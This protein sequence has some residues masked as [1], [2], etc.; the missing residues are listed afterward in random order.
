MESPGIEPGSKQATK[1]L[2]T[3][4]FPDWVFDVVFDQ[5]QSHNTYLLNFRNP[6]EAHENLGLNLRFPFIDRYK[7]ELS[8]RILLSAPSADEA[9]LT[10]IQ[11]MQQERSFL[12]RVCVLKPFIN[13]NCP[14][15]RRA[16]FSIRLAVKTSRPQIELQI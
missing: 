16:Y 9:N 10:I 5:K 2:S 8:W 7:P 15:S 3:R 11:I 14:S 1:K 13:E 12:R 6:P 4:L